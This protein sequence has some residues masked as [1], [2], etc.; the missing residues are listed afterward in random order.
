M[1]KQ[2]FIEVLEIML[3]ENAPKTAIKEVANYVLS[4]EERIEQLEKLINK[5]DS[6]N[7]LHRPLKGLRK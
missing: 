5:L 1:N 4:L 2:E 6:E 7:S 3:S